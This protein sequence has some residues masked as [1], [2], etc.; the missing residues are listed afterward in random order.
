MKR[1]CLLVMMLS[2]AGWAQARPATAA[3]AG[4]AN[5]A[6]RTSGPSTSD[7]YCAGF[8]SKDRYNHA[9]YVAGGM[10]TPDASLF[11]RGDTLFLEG[12]GYQEGQRYSVIREL[13]DINRYE[14]Y[15]GQHSDIAE[16][17]QPY[18]D[19]GYV[20]VTA[21]R[22]DVAIAEVE[23]AC[24]PITP[25][26]LLVPFHERGPLAYRPAQPFESFP[27]GTPAVTGRV[28]MTKDF[29]TVVGTGQKVYLN[30][31]SDKGIKPGDYL[32]AMRSYDPGKME[33]V[34]ALSSKM[35][36]SDDTQKNYV[37]MTGGNLARLPA[38][39]VGEMIVLSV[40]P[41][42]ATAMITLSKETINVGD[43]VDLEGTTAEAK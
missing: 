9:N 24:A 11:G 33:Y 19:M 6:V 8:L 23:F 14:P 27:A 31:G 25:G 5:A 28:V 4:A 22:G 16:A 36:P 13:V 39:A 38:R 43:E 15:R 40:T 3:P 12:G 2:A 20:R 29:D 18:A 42:S 21:I 30:I 26:D 7:L 41:S 1:V 32:R 37:G 35:P 34:D 10:Q 17:G